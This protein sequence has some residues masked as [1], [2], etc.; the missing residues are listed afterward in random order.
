MSSA[1]NLIVTIK[2]NDKWQES[3]NT[4]LRDT[5]KYIKS[6]GGFNLYI[7]DLNPLST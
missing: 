3:R 6:R 7:I 2:E 5:A 1:Y 4:L